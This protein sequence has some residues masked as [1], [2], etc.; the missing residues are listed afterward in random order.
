[1]NALIEWL[2]RLV[3][4]VKV[5]VVVRPW[6]RCVR[7]RFGKHASVLEPGVH[8]RIPL[9]D[10]VM[11]F[12][13]R[14]RVAPIPAQTMT[15]ADGEVVSVAGNVGFRIADPLLAMLSLQQPEYSVAA[16]A[17]SSAATYIRERA[18]DDLDAGDLQLFAQEN[19]QAVADGLVIEF[20]SITDFARVNRTFRLLGDEWRPATR[21]D[22]HDKDS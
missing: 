20:V 1:V 10:E 4:G 9:A 7:V 11:L 2:S 5:W 14:L 12:N 3:Q 6:E 17:Q 19:L 18:F 22:T 8:F 21:V 16:L 15:T 13:N